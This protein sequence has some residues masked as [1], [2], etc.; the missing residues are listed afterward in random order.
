MLAKRLAGKNLSDMTYLVS[1]GTN[2]NSINQSITDDQASLP[3]LANPGSYPGELSTLANGHAVWRHTVG[4][5][6]MIR[7]Y[8][9][10]DR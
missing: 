4:L 3:V 9:R 8:T 6:A 7:V 1:S 2:L 10:K 5:H